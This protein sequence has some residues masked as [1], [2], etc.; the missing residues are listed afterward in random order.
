MTGRR[1][2]DDGIHM[3]LRL[4]VVEPPAKGG[5]GWKKG[6]RERGER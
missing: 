5:K 3:V 1:D 4:L 6:K 2:R